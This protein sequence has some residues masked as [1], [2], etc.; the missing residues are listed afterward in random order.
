M[1][2]CHQVDED[3]TRHHIVDNEDGDAL[4]IYETVLTQKEEAIRKVTV[5]LCLEDAR[6]PN[7]SSTILRTF[8]DEGASCT[9]CGADMGELLEPYRYTGCA[10][11]I[12]AGGMDSAKTGQYYKSS[13][14]YRT[15]RCSTTT[16]TWTRAR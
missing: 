3:G 9:G 16:A 2:P 14:R 7:G 15:C 10:T 12:S 4:R 13:I 11:S 1:Q 6:A 8:C 5:D